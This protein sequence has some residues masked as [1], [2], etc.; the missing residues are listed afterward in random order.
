MTVQFL[1]IE[2]KRFVLLDEKQYRHLGGNA[3]PPLP[4]ALPNGNYPA[5]ET[6]RAII[7]QRIVAARRK[8][9]WT[10]AELARRAEIRVETLN[11]IERG[12]TSPDATTVGRIERCMKKAGVEV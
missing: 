11:R 7:A 2:G 4:E 3:I 1:Q 10:Q 5:L 8:V 12:K 6:A 9:G